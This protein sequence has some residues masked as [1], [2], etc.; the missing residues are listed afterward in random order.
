[1]PLETYF[2]AVIALQQGLRTY[3]NVKLVMDDPG[4]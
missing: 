4:V 3:P 1:M 2:T